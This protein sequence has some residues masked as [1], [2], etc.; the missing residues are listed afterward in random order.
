MQNLPQGKIVLEKIIQR[1]NRLKQT[2]NQLE[3]QRAFSATLNASQG[4]QFTEAVK[5]QKVSFLS[6]SKGLLLGILTLVGLV[7]VGIIIFFIMDIGKTNSTTSVVIIFLFFAVGM[8]LT[9]FVFLRYSCVSFMIG[10]KLV[11]HSKVG[12]K[13]I[14]NLVVI[15]T[16]VTVCLILIFYSWLLTLAI[17]LTDPFPT[18]MVIIVLVGVVTGP[19]LS[20]LAAKKI[21]IV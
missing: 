18:A 7:I 6:I 8:T 21:K 10:S 11:L 17:V 15:K 13:G 3:N 1:Q 19:V 4:Q 2:W 14:R 5:T 12:L 20:V 9:S 16:L